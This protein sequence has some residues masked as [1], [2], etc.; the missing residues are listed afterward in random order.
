[1]AKPPLVVTASLFTHPG[2][3]ALLSGKS[4]DVAKKAVKKKGMEIAR[5]TRDEMRAA[6]PQREG[7][8]K[9][10]TK[11]KSTR[12]GGAVVYVDRSGGA[13]GKGFHSAIVDKGTKKRATKGGANRGTMP[14]ANYV[15]PV[16]ARARARVAS[17]MAPYVLGEITRGLIK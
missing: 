4:I 8:L 1:M 16:R 15:E 11:A 12:S 7:I 5:A 2:I 10:A 14:A 9:R 13:S 3:K 6:T 17:E